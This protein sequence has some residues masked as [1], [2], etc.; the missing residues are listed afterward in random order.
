MNTSATRAVPE[1]L[2]RLRIIA[3]GRNKRSCPKMRFRV[4]MNV[5]QSVTAM[6]NAC[7]FSAMKMVYA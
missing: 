3:S 4:E 5:L 7:R 2:A 6:I 1:S